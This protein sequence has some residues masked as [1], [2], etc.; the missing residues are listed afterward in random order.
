M[1]VRIQPITIDEV[2]NA[3][4]DCFEQQ[5]SDPVMPVI[6]KIWKNI[7]IPQMFLNPTP[8]EDFTEA[9]ENMASTYRAITIL[10]A[11]E[12]LETSFLIETYDAAISKF[13]AHPIFDIV[14]TT[15][16]NGQPLVEHTIK[17]MRDMLIDATNPEEVLSLRTAFRQIILEPIAGIDR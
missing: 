17:E 1:T 10:L 16:H 9:S 14:S 11:F 8:P 2:V 15:M 13:R 5:S 12:I 3:V 4:R 7:S 6:K